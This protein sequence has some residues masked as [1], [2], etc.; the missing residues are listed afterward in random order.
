MQNDLRVVAVKDQIAANLQ[1]EAVI[2]NLKTGIYF[3]LNS[4]GV[5][6]WELIQKPVN[7]SEISSAILAEYEV[8]P[9]R[10]EQ[11][12][13]KLIDRLLEADLVEVLDGKNP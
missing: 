13:L 4:V 2:L 10:C 7:V 6:I 3:G 11:D 12:V 9:D 1:G 8:E 5:R